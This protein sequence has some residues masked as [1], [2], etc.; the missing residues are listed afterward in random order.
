VNIEGSR[1]SRPLTETEASE[2]R[3]LLVSLDTG[4][5][6][7]SAAEQ[8][9]ELE[10]LLETLGKKT[11]RKM[12]QHRDREDPATF[13][14]K[15]KACELE[16]IA[17]ETQSRLLVFDTSLTPVQTKNLGEKS[18][19]IVWDRPRVIM[20]V[21]RK[22]ARSSE[23]KL[24]VELA[25]CR[26]EI[27]H[28]KGLGL[29]MSRAGAG[30][31]TR[32]PGETEFER[33]RRKLERRI[34]SIE[35]KLEGIRGRRENQRKRRDRSGLPLFSLVGY[36]NAGKSTLFRALSGDSFVLSKDQLFTTLDTTVR[37]FRLPNFGTA[38]LTDTV[39]FIRNLPPGLIA[40]F[41]ATLEEIREADVLVWVV[42][43]T[44][45]EDET[46]QASVE[47]IL[48]DLGVWEMP[49][50]IALNKTDLVTR[51]AVERFVRNFRCQGETVVPICGL[52]Q[53]GLPE[54]KHEMER[55][56]SEMKLSK[57]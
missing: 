42:D 29:Q 38:L 10:V 56:L 55:I 52:T 4:E 20:E 31:A 17:K 8:L 9:E 54:L 27:P 39:G 40:A 53:E 51:E 12:V 41:R 57:V 25:L 5:S 1:T 34:R 43:A 44:K 30:I 2:D 15:G 11:V 46:V 23:A 47:G 18:G 14:G 50:I 32:G 24:Q 28:L 48:Q 16:R 3:V 6:G 21:F 7:A 49:R 13:I 22:R 26:Y 36:T 19:C 45:I 37:S 35:K 33:H